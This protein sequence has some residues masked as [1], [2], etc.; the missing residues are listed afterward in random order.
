MLQGNMQHWICETCGVQ[1][2]AS[3]KPPASCLICQ[4]DRQYV[5]SSGQKWTNLREMQGR[6][7]NKTFQVANQV[8]SIGPTQPKFAIGQRALLIK[9]SQGNILWDCITLLDD[10][11]KAEIDKHGGGISMIAISH[12]HFYDT[13]VAWAEAFKCKVLIH[14]ADAKWV[15]RTDSIAKELLEFWSGN[16][17]QL[18]DSIEL[19]RLGGHFAGS[20]ILYSKAGKGFICTGDTIQVTPDKMVS[21]MYRC[22]SV[23][24][25]LLII[26]F[27]LTCPSLFAV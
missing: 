2:D 18:N 5:A 6:F 19:V 20:C 13:M 3:S 7:C 11:T 8:L 15:M 22:V 9:T 26:I 23:C 21:F 16:C 12:P 4:D 24:E 10:A 1:Y 17:K 14:Q 25:Q 27:R